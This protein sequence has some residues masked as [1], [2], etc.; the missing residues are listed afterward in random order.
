MCRG[1]GGPRVAAVSWWCIDL[2]I[3]AKNEHI[4]SDQRSSWELVSDLVLH[5]PQSG[6][7]TSIYIPANQ[8][9]PLT[10]NPPLAKLEWRGGVGVCVSTSSV[11]TS[12][13]RSLEIF[14]RIN[15][16]TLRHLAS[17]LYENARQKIA[18][19]DR[20]NTF[21][22]SS[23]AIFYATFSNAIGGWLFSTQNEIADH[24]VND[25]DFIYKYVSWIL[26]NDIGRLLV[27]IKQS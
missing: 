5:L 8:A 20:N 18:N 4:L 14:S 24:H 3:A 10:K 21:N 16:N 1:S 27:Y 22:S 15:E 2:R 19:I 25:A 11:R 12:S 9:K 6:S 23:R 17:M 7:T 13:Q 26:Y